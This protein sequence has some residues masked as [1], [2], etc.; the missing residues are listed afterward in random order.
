MYNQLVGGASV[1][2][3]INGDRPVGDKTGKIICMWRYPNDLCAVSFC[4]QDPVNEHTLW[5]WEPVNPKQDRNLFFPKEGSPLHSVCLLFARSFTET[6]KKEPIV[7][8][9]MDKKRGRNQDNRQPTDSKQL[10]RYESMPSFGLPSRGPP[11]HLSE[12]TDG[13]SSLPNTGKSIAESTTDEENSN[14]LSQPRGWK[15]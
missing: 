1:D 2:P 15:Q 8:R 3:L 14:M 4:V 11:S 6:T 10:R 5:I 13:E 12:S 9:I 7:K